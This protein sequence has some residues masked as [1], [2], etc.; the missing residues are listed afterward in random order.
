M[1]KTVKTY[2]SF[3]SKYKGAFFIHI[4]VLILVAVLENLNP[5]IYKLL[6]D[7]VTAERYAK[8]FNLLLIFVAV[9]IIVNLGNAL[10]H[11]LGDRV[12]IPS[13]SDARVNIFRRV[14]D[15]DFAFHSDKHTGSLISIFKRGDHAYESFF[16]SFNEILRIL[17]SL[18]VVLF[19]FSRVSLVVMLVMVG[20]S[21]ANIILSIFLIRINMR[22]REAFNLSLIH[23]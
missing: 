1:L 14:Q 15:L 7:S 23:I 9:K 11:F 2:C 20:V 8:V 10:S 22:K 6:V 21:A 12:Y 4:L 18:L 13:S 17:V 3:L 16:D 19:F 5:Y